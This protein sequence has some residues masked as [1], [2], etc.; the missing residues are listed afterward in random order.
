VAPCD[1][2]QPNTNRRGLGFD[3]LGVRVPCQVR[4]GALPPRHRDE[5]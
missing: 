5:R 4:R 1:Q 2:W 3:Q